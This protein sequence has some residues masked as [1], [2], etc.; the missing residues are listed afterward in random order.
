VLS[1]ASMWSILA[2]RSRRRPPA[3]AARPWSKWS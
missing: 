2:W 3:D 1:A